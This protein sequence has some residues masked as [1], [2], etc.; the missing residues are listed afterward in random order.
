MTDLPQP[1]KITIPQNIPYELRAIP[2]WVLW[3]PVLKPKGRV[4]KI[5]VHWRWPFDSIEADWMDP[6]A[7]GTFDEVVAAMNMV[8]HD[9]FG[10][11]L[12]LTD[13][14]ELLVIDYD[15]DDNAQ[16]NKLGAEF[17][18]ELAGQ[19]PTYGQ[20]SVGGQGGHLFFKGRLPYDYGAKR[21]AALTTEFFSKDRFMA[22]TGRV[23]PWCN[24]HIA[25]VSESATLVDL[26]STIEPPSKQVA[27]DGNHYPV[28][29]IEEVLTY[30][31]NTDLDHDTWFGIFVSIFNAT[32]GSPEGF[33]VARKWSSTSGKHDDRTFSMKW[34]SLEYERERKSTVGT[35]FH[36]AKEWGGCDIS[37]LKLKYGLDQSTARSLTWAGQH[38]E[39][40]AAL[41]P[42][43]VRAEID[44]YKNAGRKAA[45]TTKAAELI[46]KMVFAQFSKPE[47]DDFIIWC[48]ANGVGT[49]GM[50]GGYYKDAHIDYLNHRKQLKA[51]SGD[52]RLEL[53][54]TADGKEFKS[55]VVNIQLMLA[56]HEMLAGLF[57]YEQFTKQLMISRK[58]PWVDRRNDFSPLWQPRRFTDEDLTR[59]TGYIQGE[60]LSYAKDTDIDKCVMS[61]A[62]ENSYNELT[63]WLDGLV[64]DGVPRL[65][66]WLTL[67]GNA[68]DSLYTNRI[69]RWWMLS[70]VA[71]AY[72]PGVKVD[73][74]LLLESAE[75]GTKK[76]TTW[77]VIAKRPEWYLEY[78]QE[79]N[80]TEGRRQLFGKWIIVMPE[81][82]ALD[83][84]EVQAIKAF[85]TRQFESDRQV[86]GKHYKDHART[87]VLCGDT[88]QAEYLTDATGNRRYWPVKVRM[89]A[90]ALAANIDQLWAEAVSAYKNGA[91]W[92]PDRGL[93]D[94]FI[95]AQERAT[96][97]RM[98]KDVWYDEFLDMV[99][100]W[101]N[102]GHDIT[103]L[104]GATYMAGAVLKMAVKDCTPPVLTRINGIMTSLGYTTQSVRIGGKVVRG[105]ALRGDLRI[106]EDEG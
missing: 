34:R 4:A 22:M 79:L 6:S 63:D 62:Q 18:R 97:R 59:L 55:N 64:W 10:I 106:N 71:R 74:M 54:Q 7:W 84:H 80:T 94:D 14:V 52:W 3:K 46:S 8:P 98:K 25:P 72:Q 50:L 51:E 85:V 17:M 38:K 78:T 24:G 56:N 66:R 11:G 26:L 45:T 30:I 32:V 99:V 36:F 70:A 39:E 81:L 20:I 21:V 29:L 58:P 68:A 86:Y 91:I 5:P 69:G 16:A 103:K 48:A 77:M 44:E 83:R 82:A 96:E 47:I 49:K 60:G 19:A 92:W 43:Q 35:L 13:S 105:Y 33:E 53:Q 89:D 65:D 15:P 61:I 67:Y 101:K 104:H 31:P 93:D 57:K 95:A 100:G 2:Q 102:S 23:L 12:A 37:K 75:Q 76:S 41:G 27:D 1:R 28:A 73:H 88:N 90:D 40:V 42:D 9:Y 87:F